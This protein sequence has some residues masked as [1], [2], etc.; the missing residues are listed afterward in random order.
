MNSNEAWTDVEQAFFAAAPPDEGGP[1]PEPCDFDE[2][3]VAPT[4]LA[5]GSLLDGVIGVLEG[6]KIWV[7]LA[8]ASLLVGLSVVFVSRNVG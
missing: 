1:P 3:S 8:T 6:W 5:T 7:V 2:L 4:H